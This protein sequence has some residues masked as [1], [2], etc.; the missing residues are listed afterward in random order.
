[1]AAEAVF[2]HGK[3]REAQMAFGGLIV[4]RAEIAPAGLGTAGDVRAELAG[5]LGE[6][7]AAKVAAGAADLHVLAARDAASIERLKE[8]LG[9]PD[10]IVVPRLEG[11][12]T[13]VE[14]LLA[15]YRHLEGETPRA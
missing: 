8:Q 2:F 6:R 5:D 11:D 1:P 3:L 13:D 15:L 4:N 7:L 12:I 14:G 10:P 9:E